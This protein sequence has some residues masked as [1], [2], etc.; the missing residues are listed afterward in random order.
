MCVKLRVYVRQKRR[1]KGRTAL[2]VIDA[3]TR[4]A[5]ALMALCF[6]LDR[7]LADD[8]PVANRIS[9]RQYALKVLDHSRQT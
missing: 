6:R 3:P 9:V 7:H 4:R 1:R 2:A 5:R 8:T